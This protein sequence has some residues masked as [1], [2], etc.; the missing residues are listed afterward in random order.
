MLEHYYV[1]K[2]VYY[3][4]CNSYVSLSGMY[5]ISEFNLQQFIA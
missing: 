1:F 2:T 3:S 5:S 4:L